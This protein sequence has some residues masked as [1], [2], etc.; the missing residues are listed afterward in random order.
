MSLANTTVQALYAANG[1]NTDFAIPF[2]PVI[3]DSAETLV[4]TRDESTDPA[5]EVL[6]TEGALNDYTLIGAPTASDFHT[7]VRFNTAP[8]N[9]LIVLVIR[10]MPRTQTLDLQ[11]SGAFQPA[12][13]ESALDRLVA[14]VQELN[15]KIRRALLK[16][17]T[18]S[19][20]D[21]A[22]PEFDAKGDYVMTVNAAGTA[23]ELKTAAAVFASI[24]GGGG[25]PAGGAAQE[26]LVKQSATEG[27]ADWQNYAYSGY[28]SRFSANFTSTDLEDTLSQIIAITYTAPTITLTASGSGTIREKGTAVT[29]STLTAAITK[30]S[31]PIATVRFYENTS[32]LVDTQVAGGGIPSGGNS[33]YAWTG[34]FSDTYAFRAQV[35]DNGATGGPTTV[36]SNTVTFT[37]VY[38]YYYG[39]DAAA[40]SAANVRANLTNSVIASDASVTVSLTAGAGEVFYF[41]YPASYG[42]LTSILDENGF[43]TF[44][45]WTLRTENITGLDASAVSYRIYEFNNPVTAGTYEYTFNR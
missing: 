33:T 41:A 23:V 32:T 5:T 40:L 30:R 1:A 20:L 31:D 7:T 45:D 36:T 16:P 35:D 26:V 11:P 25:L 37:F 2:S 4:Y 8:A 44:G 24:P 18:T 3:D 10:Q 15:Q 17:I 12:S 13:Q 34:S 42:A 22:M 27:D 14:M 9:G 39:A 38:P 21:G 28:S 43:E 6:K 29:S 19:E